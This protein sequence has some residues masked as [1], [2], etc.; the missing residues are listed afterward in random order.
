MPPPAR[1]PAPSAN[2]GG[3]GLPPQPSRQQS[4]PARRPTG[5]KAAAAPTP[6]CQQKAFT[7]WWNAELPGDA[8]V[9]DLT[10]DLTPGVAPML[11]LRKFTGKDIQFTRQCSDLLAHFFLDF[12]G[13]VIGR[14]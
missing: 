10:E 14:Q 6:G 8:R 9:K 12:G 3:L 5:S 1:L 13:Q 4:A 2:S 7:R 11:L